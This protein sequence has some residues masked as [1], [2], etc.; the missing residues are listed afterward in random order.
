V[1]ERVDNSMALPEEKYAEEI[2]GMGFW[3]YKPMPKSS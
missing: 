1:Q 2:V 3:I